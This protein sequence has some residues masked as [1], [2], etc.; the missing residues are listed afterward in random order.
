MK[1]YFVRHGESKLNVLGIHQNAQTELSA[2]GIQQ[3]KFVANRFRD[4][5]IDLIV[6]S[7]YLRAQQTAEEIGR[8]VQKNT[9]FTPLLREQKR[10]T[11][12]EGKQV[13][14]PDVLRIHE[15]TRNNVK[16]T[17]WHFSDEENFTDLKKRAT[18]FIEY[19]NLLT[20]ENVLAITHGIILRMIISLLV[21]GK[22]LTFT[23]FDRFRDVF[24]MNNTGITLCEKTKDGQWKL[25]TWND[26]AH[27]G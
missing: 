18:Q 4:I 2:K 22:G 3:A 24:S 20:E 14:D 8:S 27:L 21:F 1:L 17:D 16:L 15:I 26:H 19:V 13:N 10:P 5:K 12:I 7:D 9:V 6:A 11:V 25:I 23:E